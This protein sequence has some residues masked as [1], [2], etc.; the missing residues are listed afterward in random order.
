MR[1]A[2][3]ISR[4]RRSSIPKQ[5]PGG[6]AGVDDQLVELVRAGD[7]QGLAGLFDRHGEACL[8]VAS[9]AL[10]E[11][12]DVESMVFDVFL[13]TWREPPSEGT[14]MR[15]QLVSRTLERVQA[16]HP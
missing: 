15:Q 6:L 2:S 8:R 7:V 5:M 13:A 10:Q 1:R 12:S 11:A 16:N 4:T 9:E 14:Q 3:L